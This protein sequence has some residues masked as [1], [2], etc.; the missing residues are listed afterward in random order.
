MEN[1]KPSPQNFF[2]QSQVQDL[3]NP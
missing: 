1:P 3:L 2:F